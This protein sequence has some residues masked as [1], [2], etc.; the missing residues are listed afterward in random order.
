[1]YFKG[2]STVNI[3]ITNNYFTNIYSI[4]K[5]TAI[6]LDFSLSNLNSYVFISNSNFHN[7]ISLDEGAVLSI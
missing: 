3:T 6:Y 2:I 4:K 1:M 5:Y 7:I